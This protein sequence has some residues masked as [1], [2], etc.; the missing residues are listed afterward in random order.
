M[1]VFVSTSVDAT[2]LRLCDTSKEF[3]SGI[4]GFADSYS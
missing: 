3:H 4:L 2:L 1:T